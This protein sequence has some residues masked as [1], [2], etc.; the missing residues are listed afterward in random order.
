[1]ERVCAGDVDLFIVGEPVVVGVVVEGGHRGHSPGCRHRRDWA[2]AEQPFLLT[3]EEAV[4]IGVGIAEVRLPHALSCAVA[5]AGVIPSPV[6]VRVLVAVLEAI[7]VRVGVVHEQAAGGKLQVIAEAVAVGVLHQ[8]IGVIADVKEVPG[9][10]LCP[11][12]HRVAVSVSDTEAR[13]VEASFI[14][15]GELVAI[16]IGKLRVRTT[17]AAVVAAGLLDLVEVAHAV[18]IGVPLVRRRANG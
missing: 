11:V 3:I 10:D 18:A 2:L 15:I 12:A 17:R 1:M 9:P 7:V 4:V 8:R 6:P 14:A 5:D 13:V 16:A